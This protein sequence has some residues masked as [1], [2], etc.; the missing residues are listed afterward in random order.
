MSVAVISKEGSGQSVSLGTSRGGCCPALRKA[1]VRGS[2]AAPALD[3]LG[4]PG[5]DLAEI[6]AGE[7]QRPVRPTHANLVHGRLWPR[8]EQGH[9]Y[10]SALQQGRNGTMGG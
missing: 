6:Q 9:G 3:A 7:A 10:A 5:R 1:S 4:Q 8:G 2:C